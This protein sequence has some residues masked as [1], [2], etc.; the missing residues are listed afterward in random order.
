MGEWSEENETWF[1]GHVAA[2]AQG[3]ARPIS[4]REWRSW[5]RHPAGRIGSLQHAAETLA[6]IKSDFPNDIVDRVTI[7]PREAGA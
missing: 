7:I 4:N 2:I 6:R 1:R 3:S 5:Y